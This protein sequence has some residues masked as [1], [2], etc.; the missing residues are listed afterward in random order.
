MSEHVRE[1]NDLKLSP[2]YCHPS[3][4]PNPFSLPFWYS[5][6]SSFLLSSL[7]PPFTFLFP[8]FPK[9]THY[10]YPSF[11]GQ[12]LSVLNESKQYVQG[13]AWDPVG[14]YVTTTGS[15]RWDYFNGGDIQN[16]SLSFACDPSC[17]YLLYRSLRIYSTEQKFRCT[18]TVNKLSVPDQVFLACPKY[19]YQMVHVQ[20][21]YRIVE[22]LRTLAQ[23]NEL[24]VQSPNLLIRGS[25][26][27]FLDHPSLPVPETTNP[28]T[29][30]DYPYVHCTVCTG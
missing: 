9:L 6:F 25:S 12:Q 2:F 18:H 30:P 14:Q 13:V 4:P 3:L 28:P 7:S 1:G 16:L 10:C 5:S 22:L 15:D 11:P 24:Q 21:D 26:L 29:S 20:F 19:F 27:V 17:I 8:S 23:N